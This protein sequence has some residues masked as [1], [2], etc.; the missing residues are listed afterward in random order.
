MVRIIDEYD[1]F[2]S[3]QGD[4]IQEAQSIYETLT[5]FGFRCYFDKK[6]RTLSPRG[7]PQDIV[8]SIRDGLIKS[9]KAICIITKNTRESWWVPYEIGHV[10]AADKDIIALRM[11]SISED[12]LPDYLYIDG[13][14]I[15]Q[16]KDELEEF[17]NNNKMI[18]EAGNEMRKSMRYDSASCINF[19]DINASL[20]SRLSDIMD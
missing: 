11:K 14:R 4:D 20:R 12:D 8:N 19:S 3:Y 2:I 15:V 7:K 9:K 1:F 5:E 13:V 6:D 18:L 10:Q 17:I 16:N